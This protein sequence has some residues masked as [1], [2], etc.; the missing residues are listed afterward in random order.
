[1]PHKRFLLFVLIV[2]W[3]MGFSTTLKHLQRH[4]VSIPFAGFCFTL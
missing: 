3:N 1:M 2:E 4:G